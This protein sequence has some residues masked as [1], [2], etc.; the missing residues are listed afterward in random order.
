[1][2]NGIPRRKHCVF[3][4][5]QIELSRRLQKAKD[6][7]ATKVIFLLDSAKQR[8]E[9]K[10]DQSKH[11]SAFVMD[12]FCSFL[13][14]FSVFE[15]WTPLPATVWTLEK[16]CTWCREDEQGT[17]YGGYSVVFQQSTSRVERD[18]DFLVRLSL[19]HRGQK[20]AVETLGTS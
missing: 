2:E 7:A 13:L 16:K 17:G 19:H 18:F 15:K 8:I 4:G 10:P 3:R 20:S 11:E 1:M 5:G 14:A 12:S 6:R 9:W